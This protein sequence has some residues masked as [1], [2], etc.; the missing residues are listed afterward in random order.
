[1]RRLAR[2]ARFRAVTATQPKGAAFFDVDKTLL[3]GTSME[4]L[5]ARALLRREVAG[6]FAWLPFIAE[7]MRLL[8]HG[9]T[10]ARKANKAY[11]KGARPED[12][13]TW[14]E[15][16]FERSVRPRLGERGLE[17]IANERGR[18]RAIVLLTGMPD[19]LMA[20]LVRAFSPDLAAAT[21]LEVGAD[22]LLT[23]RRL[24]LHPYGR[25]KLT[26]ARDLAEKNGWDLALSSAYGDHASDAYILA[27]V[28][29]ALAVDPDHRLRRL[30][31]LRGW[32]VLG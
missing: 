21:V 16:I 10:I 11:L 31:H 4:M 2:S 24:G 27:A 29:E 3:P 30:A 8:P 32:K 12:V 23:G 15:E 7:W 26:I 20:P 13:R 25:A 22:G 6:R 9:P 17:W 5:L 19:L 28:G 14:A 18:G 1:M